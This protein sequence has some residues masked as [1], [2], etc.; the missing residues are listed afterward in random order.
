MSTAELLVNLAG[1][2]GRAYVEIRCEHGAVAAEVEDDPDGTVTIAAMDHIQFNHKR[3]N[4]CTCD[5]LLII[6]DGG[7]PD[8]PLADYLGNAGWIH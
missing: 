7:E 6:V 4:A 8:A 1:P 5:R 2:A 3:D